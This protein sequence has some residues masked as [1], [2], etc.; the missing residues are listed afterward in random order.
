MKMHGDARWEDV[1]ERYDEGKHRLRDGERE[2]R[3][4]AWKG[5]GGQSDLQVVQKDYD[6]EEKAIFGGG[7][8]HNSLT[9]TA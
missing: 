7:K 6:D 8:K 5:R 9:D 3:R 4:G 1:E 2:R